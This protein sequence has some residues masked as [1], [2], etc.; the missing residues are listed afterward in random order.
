M[1]CF[2]Q[3]SMIPGAKEKKNQTTNPPNTNRYETKQKKFSSWVK[4]TKTKL[5]LDKLKTPVDFCRLSP[6]RFNSD[7]NTHE[8]QKF[9]I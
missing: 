8:A 5:Y 6:L 7:I 4:N 2:F 9:Y 3:N 1:K